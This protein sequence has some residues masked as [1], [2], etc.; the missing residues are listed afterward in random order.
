MGDI[1]SYVSDHFHPNIIKVYQ[2][3][4]MIESQYDKM[5]HILAILLQ[6]HGWDQDIDLWQ[7]SDSQ[8]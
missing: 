8:W 6:S 3:L 7:Y 1:T 5:C 4:Q 2:E